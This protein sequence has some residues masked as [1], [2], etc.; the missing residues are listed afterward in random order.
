MASGLEFDSLCWSFDSRAEERVPS[1]PPSLPHSLRAPSHCPSPASFSAI[2]ECPTL[3]LLRA[4]PCSEWRAPVCDQPAARPRHQPAAAAAPAQGDAGRVA[5]DSL[6]LLR[7]IP[8]SKLCSN[9]MTLPL[10]LG[11]LAEQRVCTA[12]C[13]HVRLLASLRGEHLFALGLGHSSLADPPQLPWL[14]EVVAEK[15][16]SHDAW[17]L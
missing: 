9:H 13:S 14:W 17:P 8:P 7:E 12:A 10:I 15:H 5:C 16:E 3:S 4:L 2:L 1:L 11:T 6:S